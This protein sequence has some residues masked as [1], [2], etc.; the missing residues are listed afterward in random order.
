MDPSIPELPE[1][2]SNKERN[3]I[4][5]IQEMKAEYGMTFFYAYIL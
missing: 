5:I 1:V 4:Q 3:W 2:F